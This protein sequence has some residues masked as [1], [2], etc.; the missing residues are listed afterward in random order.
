MKKG[1]IVYLVDSDNLPETFDGDDALAN[2][3]LSCDHSV[4][5]VGWTL[6]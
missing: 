1:L 4:L 6:L 2:L 3:P 5:R